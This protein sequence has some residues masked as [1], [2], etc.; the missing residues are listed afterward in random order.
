MLAAIT[1][2]GYVSFR[3]NGVV[4]YERKIDPSLEIDYGTN[5]QVFF[6]SFFFFFFLNLQQFISLLI[7]HKHT[8]KLARATANCKVSEIK[9]NLAPR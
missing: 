8:H 5:F 1:C 7:S 6:F 3:K 4:I 9:K 2:S